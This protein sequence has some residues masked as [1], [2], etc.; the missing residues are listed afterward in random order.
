MSCFYHHC[1][2]GGGDGD[3]DF[4]GV[5]GHM[6]NHSYNQSWLQSVSWSSLY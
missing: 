4:S 6:V 2:R 3:D 5:T 1:L